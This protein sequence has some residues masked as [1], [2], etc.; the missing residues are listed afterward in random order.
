MMANAKANAEKNRSHGRFFSFCCNFGTPLF[1]SKQGILRIYVRSNVQ[2]TIFC[3]KTTNYTSIFNFFRAKS[4][5]FDYFV[6]N[7][8]P[9]FM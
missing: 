8:H 5:I 3:P 6:V 2:T 1:A 7:L 4:C 9:H